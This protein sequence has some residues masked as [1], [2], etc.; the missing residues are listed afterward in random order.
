M[1]H[2]AAAF[3][4]EVVA[5]CTSFARLSGTIPNQTHH[6]SDLYRSCRPPFVGTATVAS[7]SAG[8]SV[9]FWILFFSISDL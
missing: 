1:T 8:L 5:R 2:V 3:D 4:Q 9:S 6:C 7:C